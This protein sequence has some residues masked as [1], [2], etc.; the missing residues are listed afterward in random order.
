MLISTIDWATSTTETKSF[1]REGSLSQQVN[2]HAG[3]H[4]PAFLCLE[5]GGAKQSDLGAKQILRSLLSRL[6]VMVSGKPR[7]KQKSAHPTSC[8]Y[9]S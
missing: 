3:S 1:L 4:D 5:F 2:K 7:A 6:R 9:M 8:Q